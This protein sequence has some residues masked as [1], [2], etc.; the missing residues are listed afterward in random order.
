EAIG[1][2]FAGPHQDQLVRL[3][4]R[5]AFEP[6][7]E[8]LEESRATLEDE[9]RTFA[10]KARGY[11][12][13]REDDLKDVLLMLAQA[14]DAFAI[15]RN[16]YSDQ[17]RHFARVLEQAD[18]LDDTRATRERIRQQVQ[19]L[20]V[21]LEAAYQANDQTLDRMREQMGEFRARFDQDDA[22]VD[23]LTGL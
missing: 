20:R 18:R 16:G 4:K 10:A 19:S 7:A 1:P 2:E 9:L 12:E 11:R 5:L 13:L 8:A 21:F 15:Q 22:S 23:E 6:T 17:F 14:S 3:R